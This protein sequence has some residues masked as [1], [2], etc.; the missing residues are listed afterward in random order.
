[1]VIVQFVETRITPFLGV[2]VFTKISKFV[3]FSKCSF[4]FT[5]MSALLK[6][7]YKFASNVAKAI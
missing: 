2:M 4:A 5:E 3:S 1:M 7:V 6:D